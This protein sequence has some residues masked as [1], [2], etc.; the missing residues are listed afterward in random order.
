MNIQLM[1][2]LAVLLRRDR[3]GAR[4]E[5]GAVGTECAASL[6]VLSLLTILLCSVSANGI[7]VFS[8][9]VILLLR[10]G[11]LEGEVIAEVLQ[12][13][14]LAA[15]AAAVFLLPA[16]F[17]GNPGSFGTVTGKVF[18]SVLVLSLLREVVPWKDMTAAL[19]AFHV[20]ALF[21]LTLDMTVRFLVLLGQFSNAMLEAIALRRVGKRSWKTAGTGGILG[22][23]FVKS[24]QM[25]EQTQEA[26]AC[27]CWST[28]AQRQRHPNKENSA[29]RIR[30]NA[31]ILAAAAAELGWFVL[32]QSWIL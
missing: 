10:L 9:A 30:R 3:R 14:L 7:F 23:T 28:D 11:F 29:G 25:A 2:L 4:E 27:R 18:V 15:G 12:T 16:V 21:V 20:P 8:I 26:M 1:K 17:L 19:S 32:T 24:Q 13:T 5:R 6:M 22:N 31:P